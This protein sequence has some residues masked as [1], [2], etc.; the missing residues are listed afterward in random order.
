[1]PVKTVKQIKNLKGKRV[2]LRVDFN[3]PLENGRIEDDFKIQAQLPT[4]RY[5]LKNQAKVILLT[6]LGRPEPGKWSKK[7]STF[8]LAKH[9]DKL[10][11]NKVKYIKDCAG[12]KAG[13]AVGK[14]RN[15]EVVFL[16]NIRFE[17]GEIKNSRILARH[18]SGLA[19]I[20]VNEAFAVSHRQ[21]S[22]VAAIKDF[23]PFYGGL[24]LERE[25]ENLNIALNP[26]KPLIVVIGGAKI[27][28]KV[29]VIKRFLKSA[30]K[31]LV[32]GAVANAFLQAHGVEIG[33]SLVE[34][35]EIAFARS[36]KSKKIIVPID[37]VVANRATRWQAQLKDLKDIKSTDYIFDI[38]PKTIKLYSHFIKTAKT[39]V[40]N[41]P[42]GM[43]E[44]K[45]YKHGT[46]A[47]AQTIASRSSGAAF[48][49]AGGGETVEALRLTKMARYLDWISTGGG[50]MLSYLGG[51]KM[52]GLER[53][54]AKRKYGM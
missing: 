51:D 24:L 28:I 23:L 47:I 44:E 31:I 40:W 10:I 16:E 33:R 29:K 50:A 43:F 17:T 53:I 7:H 25:V 12:L 27:K 1:M 34:K 36:N 6:H 2:L 21:H 52:P 45:S 3:V 18:L 30:D 9:L 54:V 15:K 48:G 39:I 37:V 14:M 11:K 22:S 41:G 35:E 4:I 19:D 46:M 20:Y 13:T 42:L 49:V 32:G 38:G 26:K 5:L 8:S